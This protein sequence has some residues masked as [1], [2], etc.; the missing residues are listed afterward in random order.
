MRPFVIAILAVLGV[1]TG[2]A[3]ETE[4]KLSGKEIIDHWIREKWTDGQ[5]KPAKQ[6]GDAEYLRRVTLDVAGVVPSLEEAE[7]FL[8]DKDSNKRE[9]LVERLLQDSRYADHWA[10]VWSGIVV[11]F[12][13]DIRDQAARNRGIADL[14]EML[15]KNMAYDEFARRIVTVEGHVGE[16]GGAMMMEAGEDEEV[17]DVGLVG[18]IVRQFREANRDLPQALAGKL[19]RSFMGI[20]IQCAQCHDHPFDKWTQVEFYGM[21]SFFTEVRVRRD[22]QDNKK[23]GYTV[24]D[25]KAGM[26]KRGKKG[27]T[28]L[29]I[30]DSK[31]GPIKASFLE[32]GKGIE[33]GVSRRSTFAKYL[34]DKENV[35]FAKMC[36]NRYWSHFFGSGFV[37][38]VDDFNRRN[39]PTHPE[40]L[41]GLA[42]EFVDHKYD[43]HWL[44]KTIAASEAYGL[45]SRS[46][47]KGR[48]PQAE[49]YFALHAVRALSPEQILR[50]VVQAARLDKDE[51]ARQMA[52]RPGGGGKG[53]EGS[54]RAILMMTA[55]FRNAFDDDE[56]SESVD[57]AG[58]IPSALLMM[59][60]RL[61]TLAGRSAGL[62]E[63]FAQSPAPEDKVRVIFLSC[64]SRLPTAGELGRW[65]SHAAR[66][67][68]VAGYE[69]LIWALLNTSEFLFNH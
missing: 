37:N 38:P 45:T 9:K 15:A 51:L 33:E 41:E 12:E 2:V 69:D 27:G 5:L 61:T 40:L 3:Q 57:F 60:S 63:L 53:G 68:G 47:G 14:R 64:L 42:R 32:T 59:N 66:S 50:S 18:Y 49:K 48:D 13:K 25:A 58:T 26:G 24:E 29:T 21:A 36:V 23:R 52:G 55:A 46:V 19:S 35:Q 67:S 22:P 16:G 34:T 7:K 20:Q 39:K 17:K 65:K 4:V 28:D 1:S 8:A 44:I 11:G 6:A 43:L 31:G 54:D 56:G 62:V 30:P 10:D